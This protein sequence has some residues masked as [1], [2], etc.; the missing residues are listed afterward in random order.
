M[1][2]SKLD[3]QVLHLLANREAASIQKNRHTAFITHQVC[4]YW[5]SAWNEVMAAV[6]PF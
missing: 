5:D 6:I 2:I 3:L 4:S 1:T